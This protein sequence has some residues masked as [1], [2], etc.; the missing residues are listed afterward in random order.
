M[1]DKVKDGEWT[2]DK[3]FFERG[4]V[5]GTCMCETEWKGVLATP[6]PPKKKKKNLINNMVSCHRR[7]M[8]G[9]GQRQNMLKEI[10]RQF[11]DLFSDDCQK[12]KSK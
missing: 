11:L 6:P 3:K 5:P 8:T 10:I 1:E 2:G 7:C 9:L 12:P 4:N